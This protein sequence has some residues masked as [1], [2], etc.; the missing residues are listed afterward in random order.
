MG[1]EIGIITKVCAVL[2]DHQVG[3]NST[4]VEVEGEIIEHTVSVLID[5]R[6]THSYITPGLIE[7]C[8]LKKSKYKGS[9]LV[10]VAIGTLRK[11]SEVV[12]NVHW[13]WIG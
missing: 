5:P 11:V 12:R 3:H 8:T 9:W 2:E 4:V 1:Q 7:M 13:S 6:S 10:Q